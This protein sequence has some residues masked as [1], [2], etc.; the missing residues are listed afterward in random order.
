MSLHPKVDAFLSCLRHSGLF[1]ADRFAKLRKEI[2]KQGPKVNDP[3]PVAEALVRDEALTSWQA[4]NL[5][6]GKRRGFVIDKYRLLSPLGRGGMNAVYL[7]EHALMRRRC[8]IK[9][10]PE[11]QL[12]E[13]S[14]VDR[15]NREA[16]A[17]ALLD[18]TNIVRAYDFGKVI[19]GNRSIH[20]FAMELVEGESLEERV[21]RDGPLPLVEA[22]NLIRQVADGLAHAHAAGVVHRDIKPGN[23]L[24][25]RDGVVK[26][27]D[28]G[29]AKF[30]GDEPVQNAEGG[31][32]VFGTVDF[33]SPEQAL[34]SQTTDARS[35]IYSLGCTLYFLLVGHA[36]FPEG[37]LTERLVGHVSKQPAPIAK[38]RADVPADL[39][40][41][42]D[43][44]MAKK[45]AD[46]FQT[47]EEV[48]ELL[49]RWL[50]RHA[51]KQWIRKNPAILSGPADAESTTASF[52]AVSESS[53]PA[54]RSLVPADSTADIK[55]QMFQPDPSSFMDSKIFRPRTAPSWWQFLQR[56]WSN[57]RGRDQSD[58]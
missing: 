41:I 3:R 49:R 18:H 29:L 26:I 21:A 37:T 2:E 57:R 47:A 1:D 36:P 13:Q 16:R 27:L 5:L 33:L 11:K 32:Q 48:T 58:E 4:E 52:P 40:A 43:R 12:G 55:F 10:L 42:V 51:D 7:A 28:L 6:R 20:F 17:V 25:D 45:P 15:F 39:V 23:L 54:P 14:T 30:F 22:A 31:Q 50:V 9:I 35:D 46:R 56:A 34:N 24:V 53:T 8:A 38:K 44:M 19:D